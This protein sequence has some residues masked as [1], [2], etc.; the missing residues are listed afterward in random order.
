MQT[1]FHNFDKYQSIPQELGG[2]DETW[3]LH[4]CSHKSDVFRGSSTK[5]RID[6]PENV[7]PVWSSQLNKPLCNKLGKNVEC[8]VM[9]C[10]HTWTCVQERER[11]RGKSWFQKCASV[12]MP[13]T[14]ASHSKGTQDR[15]HT[16]A[17]SRNLP[18]STLASHLA[19]G[20]AYSDQLHLLLEFSLQMRCFKTSAFGVF[21]SLQVI[22]FFLWLARYF[23][24]PTFFPLE[25]ENASLLL[26]IA[27]E[28]NKAFPL[29]QR[30]E[31]LPFYL[32]K[33]TRIEGLSFPPPQLTTV[34]VNAFYS[35]TPPKC[36]DFL[37]KGSVKSIEPTQVRIWEWHKEPSQTLRCPFWV[38]SALRIHN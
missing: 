8:V 9:W 28:V 2:P 6:S 26:C 24:K 36:Q 34:G 13:H 29:L 14:T 11:Q 35:T 25:K 23:F 4:L 33:Q 32:P 12:A 5:L 17:S 37:L 3:L 22:L 21:A 16:A 18:A 1:V 20:V 38:I 7:C 10:M 19:V 15:K 27:I 30:N 31:G